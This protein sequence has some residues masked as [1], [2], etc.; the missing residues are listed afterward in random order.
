MQKT[1]K[2]RLRP[3]KAQQTALQKSLDACRFVNNETLAIRKEYWEQ[4]QTSLSRFDTINM[5]PGWKQEYPFLKE[6]FSQCLQE[7]CTRVDL[8]CKAFFRRVKNGEKPGYPRFKGYGWYDSMTYPQYGSGVSLNDEVL[9][10]SKV[11]HIKVKLHRPLQGTIKTVTIRRDRLGKWYACFS[12]EVEAKALPPSDEM[13]GIDLGL[14]TFAMLSNG[15]QIERQ[16]W[17]KRDASDLARLQRKKEK[18]DKGTPARKKII[19]ALNHAFQRQTNRRNNFAHQESR[20]LVDRYGLLVFEKLDIQGMQA[21]GNK[22]INRN[23]GDVAWAKFVQH[24]TYK[25]ESAGRAVVR[26]DPRGTTQECSDCGKIVPKDL[27]VR[28]HD[29]PHCGLKLDRDLNAARNILRRGMA[30]VGSEP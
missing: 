2:Y 18:F 26:V 12:C 1:F 21:N 11:G 20:K 16:R 19:R 13:V 29:C 23:I 14:K 9:Y 10:L 25:A 17:M 8:A 5:I 7:A 4:Q 24:T 27:S 6:A 30:S 3:T 22:L 15:E 28:V